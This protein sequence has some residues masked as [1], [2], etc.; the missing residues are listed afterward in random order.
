[1]SDKIHLLAFP[2]SKLEQRVCK[3]LNENLVTKVFANWL[4]G[5]CPPPDTNPNAFHR[6]TKTAN[7]VLASDP[8]NFNE[9]VNL[10]Q[11]ISDK[12]VVLDTRALF[13]ADRMLTKFS[14][15]Q[16]HVFYDEPDA[17]LSLKPKPMP[18]RILLDIWEASSKQIIRLSRRF[19]SR[20]FIYNLQEVLVSREEV[21][22]KFPALRIFFND[23]SIIPEEPSLSSHAIAKL[24]LTQKPEAKALF[25]ELHARSVIIATPSEPDLLN[26]QSVDQLLLLHDQPSI[27]HELVKSLDQLEKKYNTV[28]SELAVSQSENCKALGNIQSL[29]LKQEETNQEN[30]LLLLQLHQVQEELEYF[31]LENRH[32]K[33]EILTRDSYRHELLYIQ[34]LRIGSF[35]DT[36]SHRHVDFTLDQ[37]QIGDREFPSLHL[38]IVEHNGHPGFLIFLGESPKE[39][40]FYHWKPSGE[41]DGQPYMLIIPQDEP[42]RKFLIASTS[43]DILLVR[44]SVRFFALKL[45]ATTDQGSAFEKKDW[46]R[47][48]RRFLELTDDIPARLHYDDVS[49]SYRDQIYQFSLTNAWTVAKGLVPNLEISWNKN[50]I[51]ITIP[52]CFKPNFEKCLCDTIDM[53]AKLLIDLNPKGNWTLQRAFWQGLTSNDR[54]FL[55]CLLTEMP[56]FIHH[57]VDQIPG[58]KSNCEAM[59]K[60]VKELGRYAQALAEGR[61]PQRFFGLFNF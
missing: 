5:F 54:Q 60:K 1:M 49:A 9:L 57:F 37:I 33:R 51:E 29:T 30:D 25:E 11:K 19:P 14:D 17:I 4:D 15:L 10:F 28:A 32:L 31:I 40:P 42:G 13:I 45:D 7:D 16:L 59:N 20:V 3:S 55:L 52:N 41:E 22:Q 23:V 50:I 38:R 36:P 34:E 58:F 56:N 48:S 46:I 61:K 43:S 26:L 53:G 24:W 6:F 39:P 35:S 18:S 12:N 21:F 47:I 2:F 8:I 27:D 44:E